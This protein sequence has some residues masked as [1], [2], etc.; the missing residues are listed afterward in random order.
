MT[1]LTP[2]QAAKRAGV[3]RTTVMRALER[4]ELKAVRDNTGRWQITPEALEDWLSMRPVRSD[5]GQSPQAVPDTDLG[6][7]LS[8][9][10]IE[11]AK[12][13]AQKEG[14]ESRLADAHGERDRLAAALNKALEPGPS[15]LARIFGR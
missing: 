2:Q 6:Q 3:G 8:E 14:L 12:L 13:T 10:K 5:D 4:E 7:E 9:A 11:I 15:L 1:G